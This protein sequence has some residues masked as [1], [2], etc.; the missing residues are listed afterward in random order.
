[1]ELGKSFPI[2][3]LEP[4]DARK[5][6]LQSCERSLSEIMD[7][8]LDQD[9]ARLMAQLDG[10]PL[11][12]VIAGT[13]M[14]ETGT[15][16]SEYLEDY[17]KSWFQLQAQSLPTRHYH[18]GNILQTWA[19]SYHEI[20][21]RDSTAAVLL[22]FLSI[23]DNQDIWYE[24]IAGGRHCPNVPD[25]FEMAVGKKFD[26]K[27]RTKTLRAFSLIETKPQGG[28]YRLHPVVQ[29]WC[30]HVAA[31]ENHISRSR[32]IV[33]VSIGYMVPDSDERDYARAQR[34]LLPHANYLF[35]KHM[36]YE[37]NDTAVCGAFHMLGN[38]YSDQ[39]K[40]KEAEEMYKRVLAGYGQNLCKALTSR[41]VGMH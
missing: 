13:F 23:F 2:E 6:F 19:V 28:S 17:Q 15:G 38:L 37:T 21:K 24:L 36:T 30:T 26:F 5:L 35:Q 32:E 34:R 29:D 9:L 20:E 10:L 25:W 41:N 40:L 3:R 16:I 7:A 18:Q 12:I 4:K 1:M 33:L 39:G 31:T 27:A 8:G 14:R 11:A 22:L